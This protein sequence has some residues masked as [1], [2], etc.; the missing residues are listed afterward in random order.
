MRGKLLH[1]PLWV[2]GDHEKQFGGADLGRSHVLAFVTHLLGVKIA[3]IAIANEAV[4]ERA[5]R[6]IGLS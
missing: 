5:T 2:L 3:K 6:S 1:S 4:A